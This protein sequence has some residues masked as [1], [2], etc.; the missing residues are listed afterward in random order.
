LIICP[1]ICGAIPR[2]VVSTSGS[3]GMVIGSWFCFYS[4]KFNMFAIGIT[5][6]MFLID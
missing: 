1:S 5:G 6:K 2:Q 4:E 3:S